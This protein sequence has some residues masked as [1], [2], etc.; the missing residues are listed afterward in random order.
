MRPDHC[1]P[2]RVKRYIW[3]WDFVIDMQVPIG[4][5]VRKRMKPGEKL[6]LEAYFCSRF[7]RS[8]RSR[9]ARVGVLDKSF[10]LLV[11]R[12]RTIIARARTTIDP[13]VE[14]IVL[15]VRP[16]ELAQYLMSLQLTSFVTQTSNSTKS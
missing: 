2:G 13:T 6:G 1:G 9:H 16:S 11:P 3:E 4:G 8:Y 5:R 14:R 10:F 12:H 7:A 15:K